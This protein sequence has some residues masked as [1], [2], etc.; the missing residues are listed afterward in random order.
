MCK[1]MCMSGINKDTRQAALL[2][3]KEMAS[4]MTYGNSDGMGYA[5]TTTDGN[6]FG[7]R[8]LH[9]YKAF[10]ERQVQPQ[11][12]P[13]SEFDERIISYFGGILKKKV[14]IPPKEYDSFA[15]D[16]I[17]PE[18]GLQ[19]FTSMTLHARLATS[20]KEFINT[21]P[22]V[23]DNTTLIHNG[24]IRNIGKND[25][26][27]SSCDSEKILNLYLKHDVKNKPQNIQKVADKL[28][29]YYACGMY[30]KL[31]DGTLILD[32]FKD[33]S[34]RLSA[35]FVDELQTIVF[36]SVLNDIKDAC[37]DLGFTIS[38][39]FMVEAGVMC[40]INPVTGD[41]IDTFDFDP[42]G[43]PS[44]SHS[45]GKHM[46]QTDIIGIVNHAGK[47]HGSVIANFH[48]AAEADGWV[49]ENGA[50]RRVK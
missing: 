21:H 37:R 12:D 32:I 7:E 14:Y 8:W 25:L 44:N 5:A 23:N 45:Y 39:E 11:V 22:F 49:N 13:M 9:N 48:R 50:W 26:K 27:I 29:G 3:V 1:I 19:C 41:V 15:F 20:G 10:K 42:S 47:K 17:N 24:V 16:P 33:N 36:S 40:R 18:D 30:S 6:V 35:A 28:Q 31:T 34:A 43:I 4:K 2:F 38:S 46:T